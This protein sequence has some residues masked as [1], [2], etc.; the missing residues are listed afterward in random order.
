MINLQIFWKQQFPKNL[1]FNFKCI[2]C[3][4]IFLVLNSINY[5][6]FATGTDVCTDHESL[7]N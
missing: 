7:K 6:P 3:I 2:E 1:R 5:Y 4:L